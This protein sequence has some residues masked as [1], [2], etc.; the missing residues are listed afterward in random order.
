MATN[1]FSGLAAGYKQADDTR[2]QDE[3]LRMQR[4]RNQALEVQRATDNQ[5]ADQRFAL[6]QTRDE[7]QGRLQEFQLSEAQRKAAE[8]KEIR[9]GFNKL[10]NEHWG[11]RKVVG[12]DGV[13]VDFTP[14][15]N[16]PKIAAAYHAAQ[17]RFMDK[18]NLLKPQDRKVLLETQQWVEKNRLG[19]AF[20]ELI[21]SG[22]L[23]PERM[24]EV[25]PKLGVDPARP[26]RIEVDTTGGFRQMWVIGVGKDGKEFKQD[27][28]VIAAAMGLKDFDPNKASRDTAIDVARL[29]TTQ[30]QGRYYGS[31]ADLDNAT[32]THLTDTGRLPSRAEPP[33]A[34]GAPLSGKQLNAV[35]DKIPAQVG[36]T[37]AFH[38][39]MG[40]FFSPQFRNDDMQRQFLIDAAISAAR[41]GKATTPAEAI[42]AA[43]E[44]WA[45]VE[46]A[47]M[48][49]VGTFVYEKKTKTYRPA[50]EGEAGVSL[51]VLPEKDRV[52]KRNAAIKMVLADIQ[53]AR[54]RQSGGQ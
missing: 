8:E 42:S 17:F 48:S 11:P 50:R 5:R 26:L 46:A 20:T 33:P 41:R 24:A 3:L 53:A 39:D 19:E 51:S 25:A 52:E 15:Q 10:H 45:E 47:A 9:D 1:F 32:R 4:E 7:R 2:R 44:K 14:D 54:Q 23:S 6:E 34:E 22:T 40:E 28:S 30:E 37:V 12:D 36:R 35:I 16:D 13:E 38:P 21:G 31:R 18:H 49:K 43:K 27:A 29:K